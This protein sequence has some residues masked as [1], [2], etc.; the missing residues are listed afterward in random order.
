[1]LWIAGGGFTSCDSR[2]YIPMAS[3]LV[4]GSRGPVSVSVLCCTPPNMFSP[5]DLVY[6]NIHESCADSLVTFSVSVKTRH[7]SFLTIVADD[8]GASL[9]ISMLQY[10]KSLRRKVYFHNVLFISP[11]SHFHHMDFPSSPQ[12][13]FTEPVPYFCY[14]DHVHSWI[15]YLVGE[16]NEKLYKLLKP[17]EHISPSIRN[18]T[19][20]Y[21]VYWTSTYTFLRKKEFRESYYYNPKAIRTFNHFVD[22]PLLN[23]LLKPQL[24]VESFR[25]TK[26]ILTITL[27]NSANRDD[28]LFLTDFLETILPQKNP[29]VQID[30]FFMHGGFTGCLRFSSWFDS[31]P[32]LVDQVHRVIYNWTSQ[33]VVR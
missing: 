1:M 32:D 7:K 20:P 5:S 6:P 10:L 14:K 11:I 9:L 27:M 22:D 12:K 8:T 31:C 15:E 29:R 28:G 25:H 16:T 13:K 3:R 24:L 21:L 26:K 17:S 23:P 30:N 4:Q 19:P 18:S 33:T 2:D